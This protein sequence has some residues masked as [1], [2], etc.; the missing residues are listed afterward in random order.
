MP[1]LMPVSS[2][3]PLG[4]SSRRALPTQPSVTT[5]SGSQV[6]QMSMPRKWERLEL[7]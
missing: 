3:S 4:S 7:G 5:L 2:S 1:K 6:C